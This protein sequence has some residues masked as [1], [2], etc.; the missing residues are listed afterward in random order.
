MAQADQVVQDAGFPTVR[1]DINDN[2]AALFSQSSGASAP[3]TT[4]AYQPWIDTSASPAVW[5]VRNSANTGWITI[6]TID[7][8]AFSPGGTTAIANGGTG[9][10]TAAAALAALLPTQTGN[11]GKALVTDGTLASW[12]VVAA[13]VSVQ[14]FTSSGT[15][16]PTSG[17]TTFLVLATGGGGGGGRGT[18]NY[19]G[20]G[21]GGGGTA[22]RLYSSAEMG[23]SA[24]VT[25]G[26]AGAAA[27]TGNGGTGGTTSFDPGG[28]GLTITGIGGA[29]G[30]TGGAGGAGGSSTNSLFLIDG[31]PGQ[32]KP[33]VADYLTGGWRGSSL[34]GAGRGSGGNGGAYSPNYSP[35]SG[36]A[37]VVLIL[38]W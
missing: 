16:T 10:T 22:I 33:S 29:G 27:T 9:Q 34:W 5:K 11:S 37:G 8:S 24:T 14:V 28:S 38:E 15:Y 23:S 2:L 32:D 13:G 19:S 26:S 3:A 1:A 17:K 36:V 4:V 7:A 25:V 30:I 31:V 21:G 35:V 18:T 6:G 20:G 12:G